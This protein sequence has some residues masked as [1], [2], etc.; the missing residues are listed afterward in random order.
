LS[1]LSKTFR[2]FLTILPVQ[3]ATASINTHYKMY[4]IL[5]QLRLHSP[6]NSTGFRQT[7]ENLEN[8]EKQPTLKKIRETQGKKV[9]ISRYARK[10]L[11]QRKKVPKSR[12]LS[13]KNAFQMGKNSGK[14]C[15]NPVLSF[16]VRTTFK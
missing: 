15:L 12:H 3:G 10:L 9:F 11:L 14:P 4:Q 7:L 16:H 5:A 8:L 13:G 2:R 1:P 6:L